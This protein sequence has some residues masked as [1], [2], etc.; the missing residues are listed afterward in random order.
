LPYSLTENDYGVYGD[1]LYVNGT[2]YY[3]Y[4]PSPPTKSDIDKAVYTGSVLRTDGKWDFSIKNADNFTSNFLSEGTKLYID[5]DGAILSANPRGIVY[6]GTSYVK[7]LN[8]EQIHIKTQEDTA[9]RL[10]PENILGGD[11]S[12]ILPPFEKYKTDVNTSH[13][14]RSWICLNG[15]QYYEE[16][17][18]LMDRKACDY[19]IGLKPFGEIKSKLKQYAPYMTDD[20]QSNSEAAGTKLYQYGN[21]ILALRMNYMH[22][23]TIFENA[24]VYSPV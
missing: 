8:A 2:V 7:F 20:F 11:E 17:E 22:T 3:A 5:K 24:A 16:N 4:L 15:K 21:K 6:G 13:G 23:P 19:I 18:V 9:Q 1:N 12:E 10:P 14:F